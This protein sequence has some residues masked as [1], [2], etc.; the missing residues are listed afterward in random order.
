[1][2]ELTLLNILMLI[3]QVHQKSVISHCWSF[4]DKGIKFQP[5]VCNGCYD[6]SMKSMN[7][8]DIAIF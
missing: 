1:M 5:S 3:R 7:L 6:V 8:N 4:L 2:I